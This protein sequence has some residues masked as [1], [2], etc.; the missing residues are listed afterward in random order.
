MGPVHVMKTKG[1][2]QRPRQP[3]K[4]SESLPVERRRNRAGGEGVGV[5]E[6]TGKVSQLALSFEP[7]PSGVF[8]TCSPWLWSTVEYL[9]HVQ[10]LAC[11]MELM[12]ETVQPWGFWKLTAVQYGGAEGGW[13]RN[14]NKDCIKAE[15]S[16]FLLSFSLAA[17]FMSTAFKLCVLMTCMVPPTSFLLTYITH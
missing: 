5:T 10:D 17:V 11:S 14:V 3:G 13:S 8:S 16:S 1:Q 7:V 6:G 9:N 4:A 2:T 12:S 15:A